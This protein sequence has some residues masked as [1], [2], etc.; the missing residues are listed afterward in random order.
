MVVLDPYIRKVKSQNLI[1]YFVGYCW[2]FLKFL[3]E[4]ENVNIIV[5]LKFS[6]N[7]SDHLGTVLDPGGFSGILSSLTDIID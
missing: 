1:Y 6:S 2:D 3:K 5:P 7:K 4:Y